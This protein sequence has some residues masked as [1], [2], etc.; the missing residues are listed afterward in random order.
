MGRLGERDRERMRDTVQL[1]GV[2]GA[3]EKGRSDWKLGERGQ[4][5]TRTGNRIGRLSEMGQGRME[6]GLES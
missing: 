4:G 3:K 5:R 2:K 1:K 6:S